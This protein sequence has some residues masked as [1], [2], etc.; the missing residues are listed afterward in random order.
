MSNAA[1]QREPR[2]RVRKLTTRALCER[3]DVCDRTIDRWVDTGVLP[4]PMYI[5]KRRH[6]DEAEV[7]ELERERVSSRADTASRAEAL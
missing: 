4:A 3:Y 5:N 2:P 1:L 6:W 7:E